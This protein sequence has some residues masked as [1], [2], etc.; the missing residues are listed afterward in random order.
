MVSSNN[1]N[2]VDTAPDEPRTQ[3][4][5]VRTPRE[6][7]MGRTSGGPTALDVNDDKDAKRKAEPGSEDTAS[8]D[9]VDGDKKPSATPGVPFKEL[10][11]FATPMDKCLVG[12][13]VLMAGANGALFPCMALVLRAIQSVDALVEDDAA[14][15]SSAADKRFTISDA[16]AFSRPERGYFVV[17]ILTSAVNGFAFPLSAVLVAAID[18]HKR[19]LTNLS[20]G[21]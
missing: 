7:T 16:M 1:R 21:S 18:R 4:A 9:G 10:Y 5:A 6:E 13:G 2:T 19:I 12:V 3:Y 8:A 14:V 11:R 20:S 15:A 17:G